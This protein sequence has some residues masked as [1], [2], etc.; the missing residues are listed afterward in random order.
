[1]KRH[2]VFL[3]SL[4]KPLQNASI[5]STT[6]IQLLEPCSWGYKVISTDPRFTKE[7]TIYRGPDA[8]KKLIESLLNESREIEQHLTD[9]KPLNLSKNEEN[10]F[11]QNAVSAIKYLQIKRK[12]SDI[13]IILC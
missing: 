13:M 10:I 2:C 8:S 11:Q 7:S 9:I 6:Q 4:N 1:M 3:S 12:R 5:D